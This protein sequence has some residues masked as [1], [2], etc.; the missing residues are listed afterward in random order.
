M[1]RRTFLKATTATAGSGLV[2]Q[3]TP[4]LASAEDGLA[5][6][7]VVRAAK[8]LAF[9]SAWSDNVPVFSDSAR[10]LAM[11]L[12]RVLGDEFRIVR[13]NEAGS[14][15]DLIFG[16]QPPPEFAGA[17]A[18]FAG[19]PGSYALNPMQHQAWLNVGGGQ[20]LWDDLAAQ[21]GWKPLPAGHTGPRPGLWTTFDLHEATGF[22]GKR[23]FVGDGLGR[24]LVYRL[25]GKLV[26]VAPLEVADELAVGQLDAVEWGNPL[27]GLMLGLAQ[28][29]THFYRGGVHSEGV[30]LALSLRLQVW[31]SLSAS[32]QTAFESVAASE[33]NLSLSE[34]MIHS[35]LAEQSIGATL[36][37]TVA[38]LPAH[39]SAE[40]DKVVGQLVDD[41]G[42]GSPEA[43]RIRDSY[44]KFRRMLGSES[45][46]LA[47]A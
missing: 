37:I 4:A 30:A 17:S 20:M 41:I 32:T 7:V 24:E 26:E 23:I 39:L 21:H 22:T 2:L 10:R 47:S 19:L 5:A 29:A 36:S 45:E 38:D 33:L 12:Q 11:R 18:F 13:A 46:G 43:R 9:T 14:E 25:T 16:W 35:R 42:S 40:I 28:V 34:S 15:P 44:L 27:A 3:S 8:T 1:D 6:P 31:E